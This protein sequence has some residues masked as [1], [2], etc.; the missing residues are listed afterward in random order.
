MVTVG[1]SIGHSGQV[2]WGALITT[3]GC[4]WSKGREATEKSKI[5]KTLDL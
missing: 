3:W 5:N 4:Y 1:R 2:D